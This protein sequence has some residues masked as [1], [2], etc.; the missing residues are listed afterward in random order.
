LMAADWLPPSAQCTITGVMSSRRR[1][2]GAL[3][4]PVAMAALWV[5]VAERP[6]R[7]SVHAAKRLG[8]AGA[9]SLESARGNVKRSSPS[10]FPFRP[11]LSLTFPFRVQSS[12]SASAYSGSVLGARGNLGAEQGP[13]KG[14]RRRRGRNLRKFNFPHFHSRA[15]SLWKTTSG[16]NA[17]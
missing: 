12:S 4:P 6:L 16:P 7:D 17:G 9:E 5:D 11:P 8:A 3:P 15:C 10:R 2:G 13:F 1:S 14:P